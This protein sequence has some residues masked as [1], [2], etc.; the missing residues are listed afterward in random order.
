MFVF[1]M[2]SSGSVV[3]YSSCSTPAGTV[4][5]TVG[6]LA[7]LGAYNPGQEFEQIY[8]LGV[9]DPM[10]QVPATVYRVR[11]HGQASFISNTQFA[12]GWVPADLVDALG[13]KIEINEKNGNVSITRTGD[14]PMS[15]ALGRHLVEFG[16]EGF[17]EAPKDQ[18]LVIA[19]GSSAAEFFGQIDEVLGKIGGALSGKQSDELIRVLRE[20]KGRI[21]AE[22]ELIDGLEHDVQADIPEAKG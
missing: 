15:L 14:N 4:A 19:M 7:L 3:A 13:S 12:S 8:Y 2:L 9:F 6:G 18:R 17:R 10:E 16:P 5:A 11:V 20:A 22:R 21:E 1:V